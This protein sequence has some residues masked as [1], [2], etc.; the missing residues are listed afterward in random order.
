MWWKR[1]YAT[2]LASIIGAGS[3]CSAIPT[4]AALLP[5]FFISAVVALG[6]DQP[7]AEPGSP[8]A[9]CWVT[10]GTGFFYGYLVHNDSDLSKRQYAVYLVTAGHVV[11]EHGAAGQQSIRVRLMRLKL[12]PGRRNLTFHCRIGSFIPT[13]KLILRPRPYRYSSLESTDFSHRSFQATN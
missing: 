1:K 10:E 2:A 11:R 8:P 6:G 7:F 4:S 12:R 9:N 3:L 13:R 5:P